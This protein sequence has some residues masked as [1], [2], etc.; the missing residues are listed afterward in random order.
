MLDTSRCLLGGIKWQ[1]LEMESKISSKS[2]RARI[3][4]YLC[5]QA[6][7]L[8]KDKSTTAGAPNERFP[9]KCDCIYQL[10]HRFF[11]WVYIPNLRKR[12]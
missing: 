5:A 6:Q 7:H 12:V 9:T 4:S 2:I 10:L 3:I 1:M 11:L 8:L